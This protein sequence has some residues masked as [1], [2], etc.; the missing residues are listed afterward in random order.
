MIWLPHCIHVQ[1]TEDAFVLRD[2][3]SYDH[4][5]TLLEGSLPAHDSTTYGINYRNTLNDISFF[6]VAAGQLPQDIMHVLYE[7]VFPM[8]V[9]LLLTKFIYGDKFIT[10]MML[11]ERIS[12]FTYGR[13]E[14]K[15]KPHTHMPSRHA[16]A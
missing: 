1:F 14:R 6:H 13:N 16:H 8:E 10:L 9:K 4:Q 2:T 5:C 15:N 11:N 7:G 12:N 3:V